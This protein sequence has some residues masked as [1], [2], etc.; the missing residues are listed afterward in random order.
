M[1]QNQLLLGAIDATLHRLR[2]LVEEMCPADRAKL[3]AV[4][5]IAFRDFSEIEAVEKLRQ[6]QDFH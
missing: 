6:P 4:A 2:V 3:E 1:K 5:A